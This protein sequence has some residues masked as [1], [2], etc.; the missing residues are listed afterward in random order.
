[1]WDK[2]GFMKRKR[3]IFQYK[4]VRDLLDEMR[5]YA[6]DGQI[7]SGKYLLNISLVDDDVYSWDLGILTKDKSNVDYW[8]DGD[9]YFHGEDELIDSLIKNGIIR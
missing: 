8:A 3:G 1:M 5:V 2:G 7:E 4:R 6:M 9:A